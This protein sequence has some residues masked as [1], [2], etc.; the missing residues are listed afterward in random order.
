M[1]KKESAKHHYFASSA[2]DWRVDQ[3]VTALI[4]KM[5]QLGEEYTIF[6]VPLSI[7]A[8]Y[9]IQNYAPLVKGAEI[10]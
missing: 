7:D 1:S 5:D 2:F 4:R 8:E 10:M 9:P 3:D 6:R